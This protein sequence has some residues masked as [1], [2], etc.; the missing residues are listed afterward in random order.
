[1]QESDSGYF[2]T[3]SGKNETV[4]KERESWFNPGSWFVKQDYV[5]DFGG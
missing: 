5:R 4:L 1:M 2:H 3:L